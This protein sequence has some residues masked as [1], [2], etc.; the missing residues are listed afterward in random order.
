MKVRKLIDILKKLP[1]SAE[2]FVSSDEEGNSFSTIDN[3]SI[4]TY[5]KG[6]SVVIFP[7]QENVEVPGME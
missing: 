7:Y 6:K 1:Q 3:S 2:V 5:G 4:D